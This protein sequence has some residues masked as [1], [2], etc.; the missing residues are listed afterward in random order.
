[1]AKEKLKI[2]LGENVAKAEVI[3]REVST[4]N[5][6]TVKAPVKI[7][8]D[9]VI[10]CV[11]EFLEKRKSENEQINQKRCH[12]LVNREEISIKLITNE[13]DEYTCGNVTGKLLMYPK[14]VEFGINTGKIW[15]PTE[16]GLFFK[17]NRAFFV[18]REDNMKLVTDLMNFTATVNSSIERAAKETGDRT[19]KFE[20]I[21]NSNLPKSFNLKIPVFKGMNAEIFEVET[22]VQINGREVSFTL[23]SPGTNQTI[24]DIR[25]SVINTEIDKIRESCPGIAIIEV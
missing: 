2:Q 18:S 10:G 14:F 5:E 20:Q 15:A 16:L 19:D 3:V 23:I 11:Y 9:G 8:L 7:K 13:N 22:F 25:D 17:M 4:V 6:L 1:M 24:E 12:I 21:V